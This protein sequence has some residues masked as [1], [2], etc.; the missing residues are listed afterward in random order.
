MFD[1]LDDEIEKSEDPESDQTSR[2]GRYLIIVVA[3]ALV[4]CGLVLSIW[5][6]G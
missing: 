3:S 5:F 4:F 6:L 2:V 1:S